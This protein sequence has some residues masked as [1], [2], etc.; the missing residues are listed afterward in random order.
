MKKDNKQYTITDFQANMV[1]LAGVSMMVGIL[2]AKD[3]ATTG[4][5]AI[6][7]LLATFIG[8]RLVRKE[9]K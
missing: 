9:V 4:M 8:V 3:V 2:Y 7:G 6:L 1:V 5:I